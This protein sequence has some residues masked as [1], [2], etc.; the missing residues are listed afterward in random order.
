[1]AQPWQPRHAKAALQEPHSYPHSLAWQ[2]AVAR[3][4]KEKSDLEEEVPCLELEP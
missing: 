1:M 2:A 3:L 4:E